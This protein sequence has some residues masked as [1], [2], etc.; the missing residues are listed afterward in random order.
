MLFRSYG[1]INDGSEIPE[2]FKLFDPFATGYKDSTY[3][4]SVYVADTR[5]TALEIR[6]VNPDGEALSGAQFA[7]Y[8]DKDCTDLVRTGTEFG[9]GVHRFGNLEPGTYYLKETQ[10][11]AGYAALD[12]ILTVTVGG[13]GA[14]TLTPAAS[15]GGDWSIAQDSSGGWYITIINHGS[16]ILPETGGTGTTLFTAG[17]LA[18]LALACLMYKALR[19]KEREAS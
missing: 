8:S 9:G 16:Y 17:G 14:I 5:L 7:L 12:E 2:Y 1:Y 13:D 18:L 11:P 3:T 19:G 6:K 10:S 15:A 4:A